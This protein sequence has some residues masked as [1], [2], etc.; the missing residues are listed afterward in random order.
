M[1]NLRLTWIPVLML[2]VVVI[3]VVTAG[4][5]SGV[6]VPTPATSPSAAPVTE[7]GR[8]DTEV[9]SADIPTDVV[10]HT[11]SGYQEYIMFWARIGEVEFPH[12]FHV[13]DLEMDCME[14]H[15]ETDASSLEIP[16]ESYFDDFWI[17][18]RSC[19]RADGE[20]DLGPQAC[21]NCHSAQPVGIADETLSSKVVIHRLCW[22]CH[23]SGTGVDASES[24]ATC[25]FGEKTSFIEPLPESQRSQ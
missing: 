20:S 9:K 15:H 25:H 18:C 10:D 4:S 17:D 1:K 16:H 21:S 2:G 7:T 14:C 8:V 19:H 24:C 13:D 11:D 22:D 3:F 12:D 6:A 5:G 23:D